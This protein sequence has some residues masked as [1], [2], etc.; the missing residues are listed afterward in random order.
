MRFADY[1]DEAIKTCGNFHGYKDPPINDQVESGEANYRTINGST[2]DQIINSCSKCLIRGYLIQ[3]LKL[4]FLIY[5][6]LR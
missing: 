2:V 5:I 4:L 3:W 1:S 6:R